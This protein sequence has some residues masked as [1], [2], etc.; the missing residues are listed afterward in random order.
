MR[1]VAAG[2][3][4]LIVALVLVGLAMQLWVAKGVSATPPAHAVGTLVGTH[5]TGRIVRVLSFFTIQSNILSAITSGWLLVDPA[6]RSRAARAVRLAALLGITVTGIV[7]STVLA[8]VHQPNGAV[9]TTLN[10][11]FHY[12]VPILM[13]A[14]W[15]L[16]GPRDPRR[17]RIDLHTVALAMIWPAAWVAY[18][19]LRGAATKWYPYPFVDVTTHGYAQVLLNVLFVLLLS[20][21]VMGIFAVLDRRVPALGQRDTAADAAMSR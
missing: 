3:N 12:V 21:A 9:E 17:P 2:W 8:R 14:G 7:Y 15:L 19:L 13:V 4:A 1:R 5:L 11:I 6:C 10:T 18:T 20:L 16:F